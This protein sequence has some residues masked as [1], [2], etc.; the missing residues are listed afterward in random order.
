VTLTTEVVGR[1]DFKL[2]TAVSPEAT[3]YLWFRSENRGGGNARVSLEVVLHLRIR[4][5][6]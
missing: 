5:E 1:P 4:A 2:G 6:R 3:S